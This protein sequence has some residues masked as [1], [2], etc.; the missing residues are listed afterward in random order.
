MDFLYAPQDPALAQRA[1]GPLAAWLLVALIGF[2]LGAA[3]LAAAFTTDTCDF[4]ARH[5]S[6]LQ[7]RAL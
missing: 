5:G 6:V 2:T 4:A 7:T 1:R 3:A